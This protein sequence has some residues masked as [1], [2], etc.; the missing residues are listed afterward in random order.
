MGYGIDPDR[1]HRTV[2]DALV[3]DAVSISQ[4]TVRSGRDG[5]DVVPSNIALSSAERDLRPRGEK[6][7]ILSRKLEVVTEGY[8]YCVIDCLPPMSLL[9]L[10]ALIAGDRGAKEYQALA[11]EVVARL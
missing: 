1:L 10:N 5:L 9:T 4:V 2:R 7:V 3:E 11:E 8:D 6:E